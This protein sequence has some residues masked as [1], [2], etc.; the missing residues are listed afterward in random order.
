[1]KSGFSFHLCLH[2]TSPVAAHFHMAVT[3][4]GDLA[5]EKLS[6]EYSILNKIWK[7]LLGVSRKQMEISDN[8]A[9]FY[10]LF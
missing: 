7:D 10:F 9:L 1:M 5:T 6:L 3:I 4:F 8:L 2:H